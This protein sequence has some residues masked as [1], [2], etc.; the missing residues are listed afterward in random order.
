MTNV[1][2]T[3]QKIATRRGLFDFALKTLENDGWAISRAPR[4]GKSSVRVISRGR[5][6]HLVSIRTSQDSSI[7]FPPKPGGGWSTLDDV[8]FV[9]ASSVNDKHNP[10]TASVHLIPADEAKARFDRSLQA[11]KKAG[12]VIPLGRGIWLS[13]YEKEASFP[14]NL[15]GA[16]MGLDFPPLAT[17]KLD[18]GSF[19]GS[20]EQDDDLDTED[21]QP[22]IPVHSAPLTIA[23]AKRQLAVSLGVP[24]AAI[25]ITI[26]H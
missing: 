16:G 26:E 9:V 7:A 14:V 11:K 19:D 25:K 23:E 18:A 13:L 24:E 12:H 17:V 2:A 22:P 8:D 15:V 10:T 21:A 3:P 5:D 4:S 20:S 1:S 6:K